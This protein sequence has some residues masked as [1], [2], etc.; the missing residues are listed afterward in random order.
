MLKF[1]SLLVLSAGLS[2]AG[3]I[4][5]TLD[6]DGCS[7]TCGTP[8]FATVTLTDNGT[9]TAAY[10]SVTET[11]D[12]NEWFAGGGAGD[13]LEFNVVG[14][15]LIT[16]YT[17]GFTLGPAPDSASTFGPFLES[18]TCSSCTGGQSTNPAGPLSFNVGST[19]GVTTA[20]FIGNNY[21]NGD[22]F[23]A[24]DIVGNNG[25]TGNVGALGGGGTITGDTTPE[26]L[27]MFLMGAGLLGIGVVRKFRRA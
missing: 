17:A 23:F 27:S 19:T 13:A 8:P 6:Q 16:G 24:S 20:S 2:L 5:F 12:A 21:H 18:V 11:L 3:T 9:G 22:Y 1:A 10:V 25:K 15:I 26:P 14:P 7:G 4:I